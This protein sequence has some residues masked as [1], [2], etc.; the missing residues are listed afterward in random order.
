MKILSLT[1]NDSM[2]FIKARGS[3]LAPHKLQLA[4]FKGKTCEITQ[5]FTK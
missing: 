3:E 1:I 2:F 5:S 4:K